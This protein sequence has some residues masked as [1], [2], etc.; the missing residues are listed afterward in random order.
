MKKF[1]I[2]AKGRGKGNKTSSK[3]IRIVKRKYKL[4][5]GQEVTKIYTYGTR[6][7]MRSTEAITIKGQLTEYGK[8]YV[9]ALKQGENKA[10]EHTIN[11]IVENNP[12]MTESSL[13]GRLQNIKEQIEAGPDVN[14]KTIRSFIY[15]M[16]GDVDEL[17]A[18]LGISKQELLNEGNWQFKN[19]EEAV[20]KYA[21]SYYTFSF[22]YDEETISWEKTNKAPSWVQTV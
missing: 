14:K 21:G 18:D 15:N 16:G 4:K 3:G 13:I 20:F 9:E 5:N 22:K 2:I 7:T 11:M 12:D 10:Y 8:K 17:A 6:T 1:K 19:K